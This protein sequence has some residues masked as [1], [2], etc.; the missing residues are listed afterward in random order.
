VAAVGG[1][2]ILGVTAPVRAAA[3]DV[4]YTLEN[5]V[6]ADGDEVTGTLNFAAGDITAANL[7]VVDNNGTILDTYAINTNAP[8][9][10]S[11]VE[12]FDEDGIESQL[13]LAEGLTG[14]VGEDVPFLYNNINDSLR[15]PPL[16][17]HDEIAQ[18]SVSDG[19]AGP[20]SVPEPSSI[21]ATVT[22]VTLGVGLRRMKRKV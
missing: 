8:V 14:D 15:L 7:T 9:S 1:A 18:G 10:S 5:V 19:S 16:D 13:E 3:V 4:T 20:S 21:M 6:L 12:L 22:A 11:Y 17:D 2:Y